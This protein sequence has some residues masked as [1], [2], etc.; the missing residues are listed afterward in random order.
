VGVIVGMVRLL[1]WT[2]FRGAGDVPRKVLAGDAGTDIAPHPLQRALT[3]LR[4]RE[5]V[6][7]L[8]LAEHAAT[9]VAEG[10]AGYVATMRAGDVHGCYWLC[11]ERQ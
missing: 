2:K 5:H 8:A 6:E 10:V 11:V 9:H 1:L 3:V 4:A 7:R